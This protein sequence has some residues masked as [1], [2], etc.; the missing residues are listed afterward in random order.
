M[1]LAKYVKLTS[2]RKQAERDRRFDPEVNVRS[3]LGALRKRTLI[4]L[5]RDLF[6]NAIGDAR[7]NGDP[8]HGELISLTVQAAVERL[9]SGRAPRSDRVTNL[10]GMSEGVDDHANQPTVR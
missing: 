1:R 8:E 5:V 10:P 7:R 2:L 4:H 6:V 3:S 9:P